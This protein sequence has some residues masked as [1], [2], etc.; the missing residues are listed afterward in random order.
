M[1]VITDPDPATEPSLTTASAYIFSVSPGPSLWLLCGALGLVALL[2]RA[3]ITSCWSSRE[4]SSASVM[5]DKAED[6]Q[7]V[8]HGGLSSCAAPQTF[9][10]DDSRVGKVVLSSDFPQPTIGR[11]EETSAREASGCSTPPKRRSYTTMQDG[12]EVQGEIIVGEA[13]RRHTKVYGGG[14][15]LACLESEQKMTMKA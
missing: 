14:V 4:R 8:Q 15:C 10:K 3:I 11:E 6:H 2:A 13:W 5:A 7:K 9:Q 1:P 12:I